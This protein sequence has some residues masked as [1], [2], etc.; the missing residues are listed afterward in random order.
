MT[1]DPLAT[2][3]EDAVPLIVLSPHL[4]DAVLSCG[5]FMTY[6]RRHTAVTVATFFTEGAPPPYTLSARQHLVQIGAADAE[7]LYQ[8]RRDEDKEA[9]ERLGIKAIHVGLTDALY[10]RKPRHGSRAPWLHRCLPELD[11]VYPTY[12]FHIMKTDVP[13]KDTATLDVIVDQINALDAQAPGGCLMLAP[14]GVGRHVDHVLVRHAAALSSARVV[15]YSDFPYNVS[16]GPD[17]GLIERWGLVEK[18]WSQGIS[19]KADIIRAYR[20]QVDALFPTGRIPHIPELFYQ[21]IAVLS[22]GHG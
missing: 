2:A 8:R 22:G 6:A 18:R 12:R 4:D 10:R 14:L 15:Y 19:A 1:I 11:H 16:A 3:I 9:L 21:P 17:R 20:S 7:E 13:A 5:A